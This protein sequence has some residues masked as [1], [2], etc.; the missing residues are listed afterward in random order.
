MRLKG[1][2]VTLVWL[3][4]MGVPVGAQQVITLSWDDVVGLTRQQNLEL[5]MVRQDYRYQNLNRWKAYADFLPTVNYQFQRINN[6]EL[7]EFVFMGRRIKVGTDFNFVHAF[8]LQYPL[9]LGG[10]RIANSRIQN[11]LRKSL[12]AQLEGKEEEVVLQ[13]LEAYFRIILSDALIAVNVRAQEAAKANLEQV[14]KFYQAGTA[15]KLD[16]LRAKTRY[17]QTIAPLTSARNAKKLALENLKYLLNIPPRDSLVVL[18]TLAIQSFFQERPDLTLADLQQM[19]LENRPELRMVRE[20]KNV[21]GGQKLLAASKFLP[22][23]VFSAMVQHQAQLNTPRVTWNDYTRVKNIGLTVQF[24]LFEGGKRGIEY[25]QARIVDRKAS[26]QIEQTRRAIL[27]EVETAYWKYLEARENLSSLQQA[28]LEAREALRLANL[29]YKEGM[30]TQVDVLNAQL[31]F[32]SSDARYQQGIFDYNLS[33]LRL[34]KAL[35]LLKRIW[36]TD[37][38]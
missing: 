27:L 29:N 6:I 16:Y 14:E 25:Q 34:L 13:A 17:S 24:P 26:L 4:L 18:D 2:M 23:V 33:Q 5:Q 8:Q 38:H 12:K 30:A 11:S 36:Q 19:A 15:S 10:A 20:Q 21:A 22:S 37:K 35:G 3:L 9:F 1:I 32:T 28:H 31:A 7:P